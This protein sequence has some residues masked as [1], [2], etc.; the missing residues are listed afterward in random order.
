MKLDPQLEASMTTLTLRSSLHDAKK[1]ERAILREVR[2]CGYCEDDTFAIK[3]AL[4][5]AIINAV[6]HGNRNDESKQITVRFCV[7]PE[8]AVILVRDEGDGFEPCA[9][10]D[11]TSPERISL[12]HGRGIM[13]MRAY[14]T[15]VWYRA[16]GREVC[17]VKK[18]NA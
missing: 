12:P 8:M 5:E 2:D 11:P 15:D 4:E 9:V 16:G 18:R 1:P 14:L 10:P 6:K 13:L 17:L 3:L 7:T